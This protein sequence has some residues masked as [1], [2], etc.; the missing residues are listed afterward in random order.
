MAR[1]AS[2]IYNCS[3][4]RNWDTLRQRGDKTAVFP[5]ICLLKT[6]SINPSA[7]FFEIPA[8]GDFLEQ[9]RISDLL[10]P[11][12]AG[13]GGGFVQDICSA[14]AAGVALSFDF[15]QCRRAT[16]RSAAESEFG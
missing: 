8:P 2:K 6:Y 10:R 16:T 9:T 7:R 14:F 11:A 4:A 13:D 5:D 15:R 12:P 1:H 3:P